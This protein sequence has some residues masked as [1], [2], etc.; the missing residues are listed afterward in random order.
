LV[1]KKINGEYTVYMKDR[2]KSGR[3]IKTVWVNPKYDSS[4]HGT[5]LLETILGESKTFPYPKSLHAVRDV[6][7]SVIRA[8]KFSVVVDFFA[9]SGTTAHAVLELNKDDGGK[10]QCILVTNNENNIMTEVCYPRVQR[11]MQGYE[12]E[13]I[14]RTLLYERKITLTQMRQGN[15]IYAEYQQARDDNSE[16]Y[17]EL[18]GEFTNNIIRL[19]G[20]TN[21][22]GQKEGLGG[23]LKYYRTAFIPAE[24]TD[25]NKETL[26]YRSVEMLC[27]RENTF[28]FVTETDVWKI[29]ESQQQY[30][31]ILFDQLSIPAFKTALDELEDKPVSVYVFSLGDDNFAPEFADMGAR[32]KVCS[33]PEAI[34]QVYRRIYQ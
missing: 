7:L 27:L 28:D 29:Y 34:L 16:Q 8:H 11:V 14:E 20:I 21:I 6:L 30:T 26:T 3:K 4:T 25:E 33:I 1:V 10:R 13:G 17:D 2:I 22:D 24:L 19:W 9:G 15:E 23:N 31:G 12:F 32:V 5:V 18:K